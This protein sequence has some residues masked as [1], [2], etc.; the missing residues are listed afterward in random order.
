MKISIC[1][2]TLNRLA[3]L[4]TVIDSIIKEADKNKLDIEIIPVDG[5]SSDGTIEYLQKPNLFINWVIPVFIGKR[6]SYP[7]FMNK[8]IKVSSGDVIVQWNDDAYMQSNGWGNLFI[9]AGKHIE[10]KSVAGFRFPHIALSSPPNETIYVLKHD[11]DFKKNYE[12]MLNDRFMCF[13]A[14]YRRSLKAY[15]L[16]H[17]HISFYFC[18]TELCRRILTLAGPKSLPFIKGCR[19]HHMRMHKDEKDRTV[20][21]KRWF[22][23]MN[24]CQNSTASIAKNKIVPD[25]IE[26]L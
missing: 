4:K 7:D 26:R 19:V 22:E 25:F 14:Y 24:K 5:G 17:P 3:V 8:A 21:D 20:G 12:N 15:G 23:D 13:G 18:D 1:F 11:W 10:D 16:Y 9:E 6:T 2:G